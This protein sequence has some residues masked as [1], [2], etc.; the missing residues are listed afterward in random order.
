[1]SEAAGNSLL[2][3][4]S[5]SER[6]GRYS[7]GGELSTGLAQVLAQRNTAAS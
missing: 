4:L 3:G 7:F 1:M 5:E 2:L 6:Q